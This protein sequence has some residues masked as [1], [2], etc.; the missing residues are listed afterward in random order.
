MRVRRQRGGRTR[1]Q[2]F[3][4]PRAQSVVR[5]TSTRRAPRWLASRERVRVPHTCGYWGY[6]ATAGG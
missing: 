3:H 2:H 6:G 4:R 5:Q 1:K